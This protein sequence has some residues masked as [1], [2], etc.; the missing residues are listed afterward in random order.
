MAAYTPAP[1]GSPFAGYARL[2]LAQLLRQR[3]SLGPALRQLELAE[4][5]FGGFSPATQRYL[6][7][8]REHLRDIG[9]GLLRG[10]IGQ[11]LQDGSLRLLL[12]FEPPGSTACDTLEELSSELLEQLPPSDGV[13]HVALAAN[14]GERE[15][16][17]S[18]LLG[19]HCSWRS[20][21]NSCVATAGCSVPS[22]PASPTEPAR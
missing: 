21:G 8:R 20:D 17:L 1:D 18:E 10:V 5:D 2:R 15:A 11:S 3:G 4:A 12:A 9:R 14:R 6:G 16:L 7:L 19:Q 22:P 13:D